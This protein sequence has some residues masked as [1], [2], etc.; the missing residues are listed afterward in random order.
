MA[1]LTVVGPDHHRMPVEPPEP[2]ASLVAACGMDERALL[3]K[4]R[5]DVAA[6]IDSGVPAH[7][8]A[9][10]MTKLRE[11][12][13]DIRAFDARAAADESSRSSEVEDGQFDSSA[14]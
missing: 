14:V 11:T 1:K 2:A 12:D 7:T 4:M 13:R 8:L 5:L 10:L 9:S 3:V 6:A